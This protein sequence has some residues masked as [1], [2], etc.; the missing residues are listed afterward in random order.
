MASALLSAFLVVGS[1]GAQGQTLLR[2]EFAEPA[3]GLTIRIVLYAPS[4]DMGLDGAKAAFVRIRELSWL[5]SDYDPDSELRQLCRTATAERAVKVSDDLWKVLV[6]AREVSDATSGAFDITVGPIV[7]LWRKARAVRQ[8]PNEGE[9]QEALRSTGYEHVVPDPEEHAVR[10]TAPNMRLDL[11]GIAKGYIVGQALKLL[12]DRGFGSALIDAGGD[13]ALGDAPP[14]QDGWCIALAGL[15]SS[16]PETYLCV[17]NAAVAT[18]GD[19]WQFVEIDGVR[20]SH[21]VDP[22]TGNALAGRRSVTV[23][24]RDSMTTDAWATALNVLT[25]DEGLRALAGRPEMAAH[26]EYELEGQYRTDESVGWLALIGAGLLRR[27][28]DD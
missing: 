24:G 18:S 10:L 13:L 1:P 19:Q 26:C 23:V 28:Y 8:L 11:G 14:G 21:I 15:S 27:V 3:M 22:R 6:A 25:P 9:L 17:A 4:E 16:P 2:Y 7:A 12:A 5:M 20:Y